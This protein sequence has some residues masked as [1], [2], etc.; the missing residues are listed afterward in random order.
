MQDGKFGVGTIH[1]VI[2]HRRETI[3]NIVHDNLDHFGQNGV[4]WGSRDKAVPQ[5]HAK[6]DGF[7]RLLENDELQQY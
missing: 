2:I 1:I 6:I 7:P 3:P 5:A 4:S